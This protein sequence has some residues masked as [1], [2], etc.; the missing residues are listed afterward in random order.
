M[1]VA[2]L[3][4]GSGGVAERIARNNGKRSVASSIAAPNKW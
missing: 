1:P 4:S 3:S 2:R